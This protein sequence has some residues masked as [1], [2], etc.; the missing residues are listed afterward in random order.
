MLEATLQYASQVGEAEDYLEARGIPLPVAMDY[1]L[2]V[3]TEPYSAA[4]RKYVGRL[5]IPYTTRA[6]I[7]TIR[8]RC[9]AEH[10]CKA[11]KCAK[12]LGLKNADV[13]LYNV[14]ALFNRADR[15]IITEGELDA[16]VCSS[17]VGSPA[18]GCPGSNGWK[19]HFTRVVADFHTVVVVGDGDNAGREMVKHLEDELPNAV[20]VVLPDGED[21]NSLYLSQGPEFVADMLTVGS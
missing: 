20:G 3:V 11:V 15:L 1:K 7:V 14:N 18:V 10:D 16:L 17:L 2:G 13:P 12:Y 9:L 19:P 8:F 5:A 4:H 6:G 21:I